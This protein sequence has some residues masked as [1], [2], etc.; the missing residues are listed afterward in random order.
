MFYK[1]G[2]SLLKFSEWHL[3]HLTPPIRPI[4]THFSIYT[5]R[6]NIVKEFLHQLSKLIITEHYSWFKVCDIPIAT[7]FNMCIT[8]INF[9]QPILSGFPQDYQGIYKIRNWSPVML[10]Q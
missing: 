1:F 8:P 10:E 5:L 4:G 3:I 7:T 2:K 9:V 6:E